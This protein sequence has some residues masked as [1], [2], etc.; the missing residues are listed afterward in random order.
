MKYVLQSIWFWIGIWVATPG[1]PLEIAFR[2]ANG[3]ITVIP[4]NTAGID[5]N[6]QAGV[7]DLTFGE[8]PGSSL[9]FSGRVEEM[10]SGPTRTLRIT[11][12]PG[13]PAQGYY[14]NN[15]TIDP[16][17]D[18]RFFANSTTFTA[19]PAGSA[20]TLS[21]SGNTFD[22]NAL[23]A[24]ACAGNG[25]VTIISHDVRGNINK[26]TTLLDTIIGPTVINAPPAPFSVSAAGRTAV[27]VTSLELRWILLSERCDGVQVPSS[28][29]LSITPAVSEDKPPLFPRILLILLAILA[30]GIVWRQRSGTKV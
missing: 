21:Y 13:S 4:D 10:V 5:A 20:W 29:E 25:V 28:I 8:A 16:E 2:F 26:R 14:R 30:V 9:T 17:S 19:I 27:P 11:D 3:D 18:L 15:S 6:E 22:G 23:G 7:M 12:R 1:W 24:S